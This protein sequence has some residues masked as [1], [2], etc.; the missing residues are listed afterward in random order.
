[1]CLKKEL[2]NKDGSPDQ[3]RFEFHPTKQLSSLPTNQIKFSTISGIKGTDF[4]SPDITSGEK[5][6]V[7]CRLLELKVWSDITHKKK[8]NYIINLRK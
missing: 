3:Q 1:M 5:L 7:L 2:T 6:K 8:E 4:S